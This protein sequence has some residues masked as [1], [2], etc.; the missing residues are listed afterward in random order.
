MF[1]NESINKFLDYIKSDMDEDIIYSCLTDGQLGSSI[2][3]S[4]GPKKG[5]TK[6]TC[7]YWG[8][9]ING[10]FFAM[11][12]NHYKKYRL[13][14]DIYFEPKNKIGGIWHG[15]EGQFILNSGKGLSGLIVN[16]CW[17]PHEKLRSWTKKI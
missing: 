11:T 1:F 10:F 16:E 12:K 7:N 4:N 15:Q 9:V 6:A 17:L 13:T 3:K 14:N 2:N 5:I 8:D